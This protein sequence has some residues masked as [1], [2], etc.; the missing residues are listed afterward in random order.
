MHPVDE[1]VVI[2]WKTL[3]RASWELRTLG[4]DTEK[5]S[6]LVA[7]KSMLLVLKSFDL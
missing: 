4:W 6:E 1:A 2:I 3:D 7:V 5:L